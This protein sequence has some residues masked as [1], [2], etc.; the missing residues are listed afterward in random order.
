MVKGVIAQANARSRI[1]RHSNVG[2]G[3]DMGR[4]I[5][6][7]FSRLSDISAK[8]SY[9]LNGGELVTYPSF[10]DTGLP[11]APLHVSK[12]GFSVVVK[13]WRHRRC[14]CVG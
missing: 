5:R 10:I 6:R 12:L 1:E 4:I 2:N 9:G 8:R 11:H 14:G 3:Y 13:H 7:A